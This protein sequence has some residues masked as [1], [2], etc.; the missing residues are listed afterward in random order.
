M[1]ENLEVVILAVGL[2]T[3][4]KSGTIKILYRAAGCPIKQADAEII[5]ELP[6]H[7]ADRGLRDVQFGG[8]G[9][10]AA[11][12]RCCVEDE[13]GVA[14]RQHAAQLRHNFRLCPW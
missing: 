14:G 13:Q 11:I 9:R 6:E 1:N 4:M 10:E 3:R 12:A 8:R 5:L 7:A 2:G